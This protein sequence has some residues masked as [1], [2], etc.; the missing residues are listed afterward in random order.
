MRIRP[1]AIRARMPFGHSVVIDYAVDALHA[2]M[3]PPQGVAAIPS[4]RTPFTM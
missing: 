1:P 4:D 3:L 2:G